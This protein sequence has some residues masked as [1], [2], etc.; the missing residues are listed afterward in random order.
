MKEYSLN[1]AWH[2]TFPDGQKKAVEVPGCFDKAADRW[3]IAEPVIYER[4]FS[5]TEV[6][7]YARIRFSGV[8]YYCDVYINGIF[9]S[10]HEGMWDGFSVDVTTLLHTGENCLRV[11]VT[12][13]GYDPSDR[14]P[15]RQVLS[16][17]IPDVLCTFGGIWD[18]VQA[19]TASA[20]F[21]D[22]HSGAGNCQGS[23]TI[24]AVIDGKKEG[25]LEAEA[26]VIDASGK[27]IA[28]VPAQTF[29]IAP[30]KSSVDLKGP[31]NQPALWSLD[32]PNQYTY[33]LSL[34]ME[35]Q[36]TVLTRKFAFREIK[37][38]GTAILLNGRPV[39]I[40]GILHWGCYDE[41]IIPNP[42]EDVIRDEIRKIRAYGFNAIKHCLY[43]PRQRYFDLA[44]E[45]G[46]L[47]W[48][49]LPLWLPEPT[50]ELENRIKREYPRIL[51]ALKDHPSVGLVSLGCELDDSVPGNLLSEMYDLA[52]RSTGALVRD[53]SGS[54]ECYGGLAVDYADFFDYHFY[55]ELQ[56]MENLMETFTPGW[57][58]RRPFMYGEFCDSDTLRDLKRIRERKGV[59]MLPWELADHQKNPI[60]RLKPDFYL[61]EHDARMEKY[62]IRENFD[63]L[64][65]L[66]LDH[67]MVH[68]KV[69]LEQTRSFPEI[70]GYNITSIRD[71]PIATSGLFDDF[72]EPKFDPAAMRA[73]NG[74][75][76]LLPAWDLSRVWINADRVR[77]KERYNY[78]SESPYSLHVL[79]SN[80]G[81]QP[82]DSGILAWQ[83][84]LNEENVISGTIPICKSIPQG[85]VAEAGYIRFQLPKVTRP[86][87]YILHVDLE[88]GMVK[89]ENDWPVFVYP[90][91][92]PPQ[93]NFAVY[94]PCNLFFTLEREVP[95]TLLKSDGPIPEGTQVV[96]TSLLTDKIKEYM[97][98][99]GRVFLLQRDRGT[100]PVIPVAFWREGIVK[101]C[102]HPILA[103]IEKTTWMDDLRYFGLSTGT[104]FDTE[105]MAL[106]GYRD[107]TPILR[108]YD[109]RGWFA[110]DYMLFFRLGKGEC[111]ALT[112]RLEGGMGK[113]PLFIRNNPYGMYL[114]YESLRYLLK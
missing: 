25:M 27:L 66:S 75:V 84:Q 88:A 38:D 65:A 72:M 18:D 26:D 79:V 95:F 42:P 53:N 29:A 51:E 8:S 78:V 39:Y 61:G 59:K 85:E 108:R 91:L 94:D 99:G 76:M 37:A 31:V 77:S 48:V 102:L 58:N 46:M 110:S 112:L 81:A 13:P 14:F 6:E 70:C 92:Q 64:Y 4:N 30:G 107:I 40:R 71:V 54:G 28:K 35:G 50:S 83:L 97:K 1:G 93:G 49:E 74:D 106:E 103:D 60:S 44:D 47:L 73:I 114:L 16:G 3:D 96:I 86:A 24:G 90:A 45:L 69:T 36:K 100:L 56:N 12:K 101:L 63:E 23:F 9:A 10:S 113:E 57:R 67:A 5:L 11:V 41:A 80:Y 62:G 104:A 109:C 89:A 34:S 21:V 43:I 2:C 55:A 15:L 20:F 33:V 68:R 17:F 7:R 22:H 111:V 19:E 98:N 105:E 87:T 32:E 52:K 82:I